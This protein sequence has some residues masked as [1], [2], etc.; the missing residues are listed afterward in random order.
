MIPAFL[1]AA[2]SPAAVQTV[3]VFAAA[4]LREAFEAAARAFT[5]ETGFAVRFDF[6]GSDAL[7]TQIEEGAPADVFASANAAQMERLRKAGLVAGEPHTFAR[8][9]LVLIVPSTNPGR[10]ESPADLQKSGLRLVL[11]APAVPVGAYA[12]TMFEKLSSAAGYGPDY[13]KRV[14]ANVVSNELDVK[15]VVT[16]IATG[17]GDAGIVYATDVTPAVAPRVRVI[18]VPSFAAPVAGYP[19]AAMRTA[20]SPSGARAF[21]DF[22]LSPEGQ[23]FL[24]ERGFLSAR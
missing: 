10:I 22:V 20:P 14:V 21:V 11:A 17:E 3:T 7:A 18:A 12:R 1:A 19:I 13:A 8:N 2:A 23:R 4:S 6:A 9:R 16:K 15:A 24:S 5:A